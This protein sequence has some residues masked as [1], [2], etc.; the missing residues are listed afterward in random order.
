[1]FVAH[2]PIQRRKAR[3]ELTALLEVEAVQEVEHDARSL[4][5]MTAPAT[6]V[7]GMQLL[8]CKRQLFQQQIVLR[9][10]RR[11]GSDDGVSFGAR[12]ARNATLARATNLRLAHRR[13]PVTDNS[14]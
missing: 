14:G 7:P 12:V 5:E 2:I 1:K 8:L 10:H 13:Y 4:L 3:H 11:V 6:N 9:W